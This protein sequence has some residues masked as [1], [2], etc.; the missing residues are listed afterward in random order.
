MLIINKLPF[1]KKF[2]FF[3]L[4]SYLTIIVVVLFSYII[5]FNHKYRFDS[6]SYFINNENDSIFESNYI[7]SSQKSTKNLSFD[8]FCENLG[9]WEPLSDQNNQKSSIFFKR[10][11]SFYFIDGAF[12]RLHFLSMGQ[13]ILLN[14]Y[15]D[16]KLNDNLIVSQHKIN[17]MNIVAPWTV[18]Y[19]SFNFLDAK[20]NLIDFLVK[21]NIH[22]SNLTNFLK[23][24]KLNIEISVVEVNTNFKNFNQ[25]LS[26]KTKLLKSD[27]N[28][29]KN[30]IVCA[31]CLYLSN[32]DNKY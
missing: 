18:R 2:F 28:S 9:E 15:V 13:T 11:G 14:L 22:V 31:K 10:S 26:V 27:F 7:L 19:Y 20:F 25:K 21:N 4:F 3:L 24:N 8:D 23:T 12:F 30:S 17:S 6:F 32:G 5:K 1:L 16:V 29:K